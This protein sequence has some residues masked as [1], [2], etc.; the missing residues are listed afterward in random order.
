MITT[1]EEYNELLWKIQDQNA[2][3]SAV[4][5]PSTENVYLIDLE[6]RT[7]GA[8]DFL[9]VQTDHKAETIF[10]LVDRFYDG[11]D[12][13]T[14]T[15]V[16]QYI[17]ANGEGRIYPVP[18]YDVTTY[19]GAAY[20]DKY[21]KSLVTQ[22]NYQPNKFF[23]Q[24]GNNGYILSSGLF[25]PNLTY[26]SYIDSPKILFPWVIGGE[27][28]RAAGMVE[29]SVRFYT[30]NE[31]GSKFTYTLNTRTAKSKVLYGMDVSNVEEYDYPAEVLE[32]IYY[33]LN[34]LEGDYE[35]YWIEV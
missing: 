11:V 20:S 21:I 5:L 29:Y 27:A 34:R 17:N 35:L 31:S 12:L 28:T 33:R 14:T 16:V 10:F 1:A 2:P 26:Y 7:I 23:I 8:P 4:L 9:S 32:D 24:D 15:C 30:I 13:A 22:E 19:S 6:A 3:V 25:N 18:F